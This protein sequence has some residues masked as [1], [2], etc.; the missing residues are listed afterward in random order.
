MSAQLDTLCS[1]CTTPPPQMAVS[2]TKK[3]NHYTAGLTEGP[4]HDHSHRHHNLICMQYLSNLYDLPWASHLPS[5][6]YRVHLNIQDNQTDKSKLYFSS[7]SLE[8][9]GVQLCAA[10]VEEVFAKL[11]PLAPKWW[12]QLK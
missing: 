4:A 9:E 2:Q 7:N 1:T 3:Y 12:S 10:D 5:L 8:V 6:A 11:F